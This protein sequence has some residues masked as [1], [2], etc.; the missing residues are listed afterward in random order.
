MRALGENETL[1]MPRRQPSGEFKAKVV[2]E[3]LRGARPIQE[4]AA[5]YGVHPLQITPWQRVA[6]AEWPE[7]VS[8]R[9]GP[10]STDEEAFTAALYQQIGPVTVAV[11][12]LNTKVG[13]RR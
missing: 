3:A 5:E 4:L 7:V 8:N 1:S 9:R 13:H 12:W 10:T 11:D 6:L 2:L